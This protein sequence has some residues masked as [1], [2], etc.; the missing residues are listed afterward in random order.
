[1][2]TV[3]IVDDDPAIREIFTLTL[4]RSGYLVHAAPG[5]KECLGLLKTVQPDLLLLDIMMAPMDGWETLD[6]IKRSD[7]TRQVPVIMLSAKPPTRTEIL[8]H[9]SQIEDYIFK[10]IELA[11]LSRS[12]ASVIEHC[13]DVQREAE[14]LEKAGSERN[15]ID[16]YYNRQRRVTIFNKL[17]PRFRGAA[18]G[19]EDM[20]RMLEEELMRIRKKLEQ[21]TSG[22]L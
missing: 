17:V 6:A 2:Q 15:A 18:G 9:G 21:G 10:P 13:R 5:G 20:I 1:M 11:E 19:D 16:E 7:A 22:P 12:V 3:M 14:N 4:E 8:E